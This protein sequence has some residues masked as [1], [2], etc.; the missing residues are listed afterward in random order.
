[1]RAEGLAMQYELRLNNGVRRSASQPTNP[2]FRACQSR[3]VN[4][5]LVTLGNVCRGCLELCDVRTV[6]KLSLE[7]APQDCA[8]GH[9]WSIFRD[10]LRRTLGEDYWFE[11]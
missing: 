4:L 7:V 11:R 6:S 3:R 8:A 1:M 9:G 10:E 5:E 2:P